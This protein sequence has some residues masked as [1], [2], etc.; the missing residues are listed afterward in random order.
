MRAKE[1]QAL[2][3]RWLAETTYGRPDELPG[4]LESLTWVNMDVTDPDP[5]DQIIF[6]IRGTRPSE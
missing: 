4:L 5:I 2:F 3:R 1:K 6:G